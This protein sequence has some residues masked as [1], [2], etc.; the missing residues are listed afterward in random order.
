[1]RKEAVS[2][3]QERMRNKVEDKAQRKEI[4]EK[5]H[6]QAGNAMAE[7]EAKRDDNKAIR[8]EVKREM[9]EALK[10]RRD[11]DAHELARKEELIR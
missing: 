6:A 11:E 4:I 9:D 5:I 3:D 2:R 8:D 7:M 1:M 10:R